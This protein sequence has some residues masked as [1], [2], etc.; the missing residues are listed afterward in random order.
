MCCSVGGRENLFPKKPTV[1]TIYD[2]KD[3][4]EDRR[5]YFIFMDGAVF[6]EKGYP[7]GR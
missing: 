2:L 5:Y 6:I 1:W 3:S 7:D 4:K